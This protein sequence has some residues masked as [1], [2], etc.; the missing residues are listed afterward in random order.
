MSKKNRVSF[1][2]KV[3]LP[4][5]LHARSIWGHTR[6]GSALRESISTSKGPIV[7]FVENLD[8]GNPP[9]WSPAVRLK[10]AGET[11]RILAGPNG[12][13]QGPA[14]AKWGYTVVDVADWDHD[15]KL[16]VLLNSIW[17]KVLWYRNAQGAG[18]LEL[19]AARA[20]RILGRPGDIAGIIPA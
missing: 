5:R 13:I 9:Q 6:I 7:N 18:T 17:G 10:S 12:S 20:D 16:D 3:R 19:E 15:G 1:M 14:E 8:G 11:L 2:T 4:A